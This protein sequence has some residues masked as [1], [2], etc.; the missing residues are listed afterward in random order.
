[1]HLFKCLTAAFLQ[2]S[3]PSGGTPETGSMLLPS[4]QLQRA[5]PDASAIRVN[6]MTQFVSQVLPPSAEKACSKRDEVGVIF[7]E[8][9]SHQDTSVVEDLLIVELAASILELTNHG[10]G[11]HA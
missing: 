11:Q 8:A 3:A 2:V 6:V 10:L 7:R 5:G 4:A 9:V 1:M